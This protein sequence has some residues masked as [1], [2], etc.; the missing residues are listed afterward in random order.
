[1]VFIILCFFFFFKHKTAYEMRISDWSS[2]VCSSDLST[3]S[4]PVHAGRRTPGSTAS[5]FTRRRA[6]CQCSF[7]RQTPICGPT[8]GAAALS[9]D[10]PSFWRSWT[11]SEEHTSELQSLMRISYAVFCLKKKKQHTESYQNLYSKHANVI[12][13]EQRTQ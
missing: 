12:N 8:N 13:K 4:S 6:I 2:D 1:M 5:R 9:A 11:R 10:R 3:I 7:F